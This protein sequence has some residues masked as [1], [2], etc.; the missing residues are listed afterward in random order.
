MRR[1]FIATLVA[2]AACG[3]GIKDAPLTEHTME[4]VRDSKDLTETDRTLLAGYMARTAW[5]RMQKGGDTTPEFF[6]ENVT[7]GEAI[8]SQ[9]RWA[10]QDSARRAGERRQADEA[11]QRRE[12]DLARARSAASV[13]VTGKRQQPEDPQAGRFSHHAVL[14]VAVANT[15]DRAITGIK[16]RLVVR[17]LFD[18]DVI[19]LQFKHDDPLAPGARATGERFYEINRYIDEQT[20]LYGMEMEKLR[21]TW[22]PQTILFA[23]GSKL[24]V[25]EPPAADRIGDLL[26]LP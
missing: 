25:A 7:V 3:G 24:E 20:R 11:R 18:D 10:A 2:L 15:G 14:T 17:D 22:E 19:A 5:D 4:R 1:L 23:D 21:F 16:G 26:R 6:D 8:E 9:R 12:A 13:T